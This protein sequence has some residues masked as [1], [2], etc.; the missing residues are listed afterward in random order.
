MSVVGCEVGIQGRAFLIKTT[1]DGT[2]VY[3]LIRRYIKF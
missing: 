1:K 2:E 3:F